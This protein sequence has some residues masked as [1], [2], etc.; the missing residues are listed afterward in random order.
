MEKDEEYT[1][2]PKLNK[3]DIKS[4]FNKSKSIEKDKVNEIFINRYNKAREFYMTKKIKQLSNKDESYSTMLNEYNY[5]TSKH[6]KNKKFNFSMN[7]YIN[8][9]TNKNNKLIN[10]ENSIVQRLRNELLDINLNEDEKL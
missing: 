8:T 10:I 1:F 4:I 6:R 5:F 3:G 2:K 7:N 9:E